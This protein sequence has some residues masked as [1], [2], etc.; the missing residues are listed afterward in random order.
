[1]SL[2]PLALLLLLSAC[3]RNPPPQKPP[4]FTAMEQRVR[5][6]EI[7]VAKLK[8]VPP[9]GETTPAKGGKAKVAKSP[10]AIKEASRKAASR[11][12]D[13]DDIE[14]IATQEPPPA[15][16]GHVQLEG[17]VKQVHLLHQ[18][19][20]ISIPGKI[21]SGS[22]TIVAVFEQGKPIQAGSIKV[23][24]GQKLTITCN[25]A[26]KTCTSS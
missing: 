2:S 4:E 18:R 20:K 17:D 26:S 23:T 12:V 1:M 22:Y 25:R 5:T 9:P 15:G 7:E 16:F 14:K 6:L 24:G 19:K 21:A 10:R 13:P 3:G 11:P 8:G